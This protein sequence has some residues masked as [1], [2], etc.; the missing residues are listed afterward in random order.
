LKKID[1]ILF[2]IAVLCATVLHLQANRSIMRFSVDIALSKKITA[3]AGPVILAMLSQTAINL[4]D[5]AMVG[6][7]PGSTGIDGVAGIGV[8]LPLFWAIGGFLSAIAIGTQAITARRTGEEK[9][10]LAGRA[11]TNSLTVAFLSGLSMSILGYYY[12]PDIFPFL[13]PNPN[14][15][16]LGSDYCSIRMLGVVSMV[17]TI[18]YK[19]FFDGVGKTHIHMVASIVMNILNAF[20]NVVL[21]FGFLGF[22]RMEVE[23]AAIASLISTFVGL[24]IMIIWSFKKDLLKKYHYYRMKNLNRSVVYE[25][26]RLSVPSGLATVF[27]MSGFQFFMWVTGN[28]EPEPQMLAPLGFIPLA[29]PILL[30]IDFI[31]PDLAT[32]AS[33]VLISF[34]MLIFMTSIAFGTATATLAGQSMGSKDFDLAERYGWESVKIGMYSMGLLGIAMIVWPHTFLG[35]FTD[36]TE[37]INAAVP[38]MRLMA[39]TASMMSAGLILVQALFGAGNNKFVMV[40][41]LLLH[42]LCLIPLS[43]VLA[44][45]LDFGMLGAWMASATYIVLLSSIMAWKFAQGTWKKIKI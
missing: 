19:G 43:Y 13:N 44:M 16:R 24:A 23:G 3:L 4:L 15:I 45:V 21:I 29:G 5:T 12:V 6:R 36:K 40:A 39:S 28:L 25:L 35:I 34:L 22:P 10:E 2:E 8:S 41:E 18:S 20:L 31:T 30:G 42:A 32:S 26:C 7:L 14:V 27:V 38:S 1:C 33:W 17:T 37:V 9:H 11:L